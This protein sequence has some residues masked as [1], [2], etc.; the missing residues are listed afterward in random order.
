M[1]HHNHQIPRYPFIPHLR[2]E[3]VGVRWDSMAEEQKIKYCRDQ[4]MLTVKD[5]VRK[6]TDVKARLEQLGKFLRKP[7]YAS[8]YTDQEKGKIHAMCMDW[9]TN[10]V[11]QTRWMAIRTIHTCYLR[12]ESMLRKKYLARKNEFLRTMGIR[13][14]DREMT[15]E[16]LFHQIFDDPNQD[17]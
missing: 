9:A 4:F 7:F 17:N 11:P 16:E 3:I 12:C 10:K 14:I 2:E 5:L 15:A 8:D 1:H 13:P 6:D